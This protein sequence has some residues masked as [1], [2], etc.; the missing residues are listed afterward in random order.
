METERIIGKDFVVTITGI[1]TAYSKHLGPKEI[2]EIAR[3]VSGEYIR[4]R[5]TLADGE[6]GAHRRLPVDREGRGCGCLALSRGTHRG[7]WT[8]RL[9]LGSSMS[10][11]SRAASRSA[12]LGRA[13]RPMGTASRGRG[14]PPRRRV[15]GAGRRG[16][17]AEPPARNQRRKRR[18]RG[19]RSAELTE[20]RAAPAGPG[21][22]AHGPS[23]FR[24]PA[25]SFSAS[26]GCSRPI[27]G[28]GC[29]Y[30]AEAPT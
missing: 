9:G 12:G 29:A 26:R 19:P 1:W 3:Q 22:V 23:A 2:E 14:W 10:T 28:N 15:P 16:R 30:Q 5:W 6:K 20:P 25:R 21:R 4:S 18:I 11:S 7:R 24:R 17:Q 8:S 27:P 13:A